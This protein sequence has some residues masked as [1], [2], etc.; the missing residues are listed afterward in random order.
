MAKQQNHKSSTC[1]LQI[2]SEFKALITQQTENQKARDDNLNTLCE[3]R[4]KKPQTNY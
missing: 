3:L 1:K 2:N 4:Q